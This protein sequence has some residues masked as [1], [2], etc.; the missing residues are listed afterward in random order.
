[1][2]YRE[3][4]LT[5]QLLTRKLKGIKERSSEGNHKM[6]SHIRR[7]ADANT[8]IC[9]ICENP[10]ETIG[11]KILIQHRSKNIKRWVH[12]LCAAEKNII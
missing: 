9:P 3:I 4:I 1:M 11:E 12:I 6:L 5:R 10:I 8:I 7:M 2:T